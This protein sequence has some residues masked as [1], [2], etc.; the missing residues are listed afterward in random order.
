MRKAEWL[1]S[2]VKHVGSR[3]RPT[4][5]ILGGHPIWGAARFTFT[6]RVQGGMAKFTVTI[7]CEP[8]VDDES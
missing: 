4:E 5:P 3:Y 6:D 1:H 8:T 2:T 7:T